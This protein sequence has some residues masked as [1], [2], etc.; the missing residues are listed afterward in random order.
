MCSLLPTA[1]RAPLLLAQR[2]HQH[3][4]LMR[5][6]SDGIHGPKRVAAELFRPKVL[7]FASSI[8]LY[9][10]VQAAFALPELMWQRKIEDPE[11]PDLALLEQ[12]TIQPTV[13]R[14]IFTFSFVMLLSQ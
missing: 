1:S 10:P 4:V 11:R 8:S 13:L 7:S 6:Q 5:W 14:C 9:S 2:L 3:G 12:A